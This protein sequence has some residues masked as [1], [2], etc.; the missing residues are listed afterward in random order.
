ML[1]ERRACR[2]SCR[3][4]AMAVVAVVADPHLGLDEHLVA[5]HARAADGLADLAFVAVGSSGIDEPVSRLQR[6]MHGVCGDVRGRLEHP[7]ARGEASTP[8]LFSVRFMV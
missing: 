2:R 8:P 1:A 5:G 7:E 4:R 6:R 3:T